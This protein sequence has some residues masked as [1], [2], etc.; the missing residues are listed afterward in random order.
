MASEG[1]ATEVLFRNHVS[2]LQELHASL[3][4]INDPAVELTVGR[5]CADVSRCVNVLRTAGN[6]LSTDALLEHEEALDAYMSKVVGGD[7]PALAFE[8]AALG[9]AQGGLGSGEPKA[10][11]SRLLW[12]RALKRVLSWPTYSLTWPLRAFG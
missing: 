1:A 12:L 3:S 9:V 10:W 11:R 4:E 5:A 6:Q 7:L 2:K 8:Q